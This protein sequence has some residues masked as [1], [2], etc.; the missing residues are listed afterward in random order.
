MY[1]RI[2]LKLSGEALAG[3]R[4]F[5]IDADKV[6]DITAEIAEVH[7][8]GVEVAIVVGG[9]NF[10]RG[11][12]EQAKEMDRVSADNMGMLS[13]V[14]NAIALQDALEQRKVQC[15]VMTAVFMNQIA[16]PYIRRRATRHLE[17]GRV[18][19]FAAGTGN[20]FFSTDT[21]ASLRAMEIKADVLLKAT[22]VEGIYNA[23]PVLVKDAVKYEQIS[24][25]EIVKQGLKVMDLTAVTLCKDN[26]MPMIVF[27]MNQPGNIRRV[28]MGE[29][30]GSLVTA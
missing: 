30:V 21:A 9:G 29:R 8:L 17:K 26:N 23:D 11:I 12:A 13:T 14:I 28:V 20:P 4:G 16:E 19:V 1:K 7:D 27:N 15:R 10:F 6:S 22:K 3:D 24:Y 25:M 2:V 5:G 18:V